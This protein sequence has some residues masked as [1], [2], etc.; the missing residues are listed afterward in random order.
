[1]KLENTQTQVEKEKISQLI[2][3]TIHGGLRQRIVDEVRDMCE[4]T[5]IR[6]IARRAVAEL[7]E[8]LKGLVPDEYLNEALSGF[9][10]DLVYFAAVGLEGA[11][12]KA[13]EL[14][15]LGVDEKVDMVRHGFLRI[16][17]VLKSTLLPEEV[18]KALWEWW[19]WYNER[20]VLSAGAFLRNDGLRV[21]VTYNTA[22]LFIL[23]TEWC[24]GRRR[25]DCREECEN[26]MGLDHVARRTTK[27]L[28]EILDEYGVKHGTTDLTLG[29]TKYVCVDIALEKSS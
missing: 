5:R 20:F 3:E 11:V 6:E 27:R 7:K 22:R 19:E 8:A 2:K 1:M 10:E 23:C 17:E 4:V 18:K 25:D 16:P 29:N 13:F 24:V 28:Q 21:C 14:A 26:H 15:V 12:D 9:P